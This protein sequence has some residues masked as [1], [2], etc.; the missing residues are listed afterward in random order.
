MAK[1]T[2]KKPYKPTGVNRSRQSASTGRAK[3]GDLSCTVKVRAPKGPTTAYSVRGKPGSAIV[4]PCIA[5]LQA[6]AKRVRKGR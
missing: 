1:S 2:G 4:K 6:Q 3:S 5:A